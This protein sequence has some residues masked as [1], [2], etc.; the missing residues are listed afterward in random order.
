MTHTPSSPGDH[1][2]LLALL[3]EHIRDH[4]VFEIDAAGNIVAG[5]KSVLRIFGHDAGQSAGLSLTRLYPHGQQSPERMTALIT[6]AL[7]KGRAE[8]ESRYQRRNGQVFRAHTVIL[9]VTGAAPPRFAVVVRDLSILMASQ[10]QLHALAT[11]DMLTG[12]D[13]RQHVF[14]LGRVEYRRWRRYRVPLS[15]ILCEVDSMRELRSRCGEDMADD[16]LRNMADL[17]RQ[18]VREVD[19]VARLEGGLFCAHMFSTPLEGACVVGERIRR[20][21]ATT[22]LHDDKITASLVIATANDAANDFDGFFKQLEDA[23]AEARLQGGN[24]LIVL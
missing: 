16:T 6:D 7:H 22:S 4:A 10:D 11:L 2:K 20:S 3:L 19:V 8:E 1:E 18:S 5:N 12:L 13:N 23:L 14:D 9:P 21:V 24:R 17:L 15:L